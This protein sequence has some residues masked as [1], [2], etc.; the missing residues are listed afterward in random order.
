MATMIRRAR[1]VLKLKKKLTNP[2]MAKAKKMSS[3]IGG[4]A[5]VFATPNPTVVAVQNQ[6]AV[7]DKAEVLVTTHAVGAAA[8]RDV[9]LAALVGMLEAWL[10]YVQGVADVAST[11][12]QAVSIIEAAGLTPAASASRVKPLLA[13][14][15]AMPGGPVLL[16]ANVGELIGKENLRKKTQINW[17]CTADGGKT[18][19]TLPSTPKGKTTVPALTPLTAYGF[20]VSFTNPDGVMQPWSQIVSFLVH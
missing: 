14:S 7:V 9:G 19:V 20:R 12:E 8:A 17:E 18:F 2:V 13:A 11:Y 4:A 15:Q 10:I 3:S 5:A 16:V 6:I 1:A